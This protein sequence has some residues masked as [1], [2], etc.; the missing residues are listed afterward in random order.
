MDTRGKHLGRRVWWTR[1][2]ALGGALVVV[3]GGSLVGLTAASSGSTHSSAGSGSRAPA[4]SH[5]PSS[6]SETAIARAQA[7][8]AAAVSVSPAPGASGVALN[9]PVS[10]STATGS[11]LS[12]QVVNAAGTAVTGT[13]APTHTA[14]RSATALQPTST[15]RVVATVARPDGLTAQRVAT[16]TT[17]TPTYLIGATAFPSDGM[18]VGVGQPIVINFDHYVRT[19]A[20]QAAVL[21]HIAVSMSRPVPG[22]WHWFSLDE[23]H[24]RPET[25]WPAGEKVTVTANLDGWDAGLGRWGHGQISDTF[26]IGDARISV[27]NLATDEMTVTLNGATFATYPISGGRQQYPTMDGTHIVLDRESVVHMVSSTVGIPV[28]SPNGYDEYVYDDVHI[29]DSGEYVHSAP[30]SVGSQ[31]VTN[32]S[33]GCINVSPTNALAF[34]NFS[35]IGDVIQVVGGPRPPVAG[36]HGVMDWSTDWSQW[37]PAVVHALA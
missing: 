4:G 35:R 28:D 20:G 5:Q 18:T 34:F 26:S 29:S 30:W 10:V 33:H 21:S 14:W 22:G 11:L 13:L 9:A 31:G 36:D 37:T 3:V 23:L 24:F 15:Y 2:W 16:F 1:W 17:L 19:T 8:L 25:Y 27:A 7:Q 6:R 12:V 32:V